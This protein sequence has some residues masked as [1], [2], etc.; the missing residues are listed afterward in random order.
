MLDKDT[1]ICVATG[2]SHKLSEIKAILKDVLQG[3]SF[4]SIKELGSFEDPIEDGDTFYANALIKAQ[5]AILQTGCMYAIADDS[6]L[7]VDELD[8]APGIYSARWAGIH[9]D[10]EANNNKLLAELS[11]VEDDKRTAHFHSSVVLVSRD[12]LILHGEGKCEGKIGYAPQGEHGFGYDPL[13]WPDETQGKT[14][15]ELTSDEKNKISH[16]FYALLDLSEQI[17]SKM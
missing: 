7:V 11:G 10:D 16:R 4:V 1:T 9:G 15:A 3:Y 13:F 8:G 12:N 6:G 5:D 2:N 14:M 17:K